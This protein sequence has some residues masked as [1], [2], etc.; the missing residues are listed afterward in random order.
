MGGR[1][2]QASIGLLLGA[3]CACA[4][5][6]QRPQ[7]TSAMASQEAEKQAELAV[8]ERVKMQAR[9]S[10]VMYRLAR[11]NSDLCGVDVAY[12]IGTTTATLDS[13]EKNFKPAYQTAFSLSDQP[14]VLSIAP[15]SPASAAGLAPGDII[16]RLNGS[17]VP[18]GERGI[19]AFT[20]ALDGTY[21][22][23]MRLHVQHGNGKEQDIDLK[24]DRVCKY[25]AVVT[26]D[27]NVNAMAD[28]K[29]IAVTSGLLRFIESDDEL[30]LVLGHELGHDAMG[31]IKSQR[32]NAAVGAFV[33]ALLSVATGVN[34]VDAG[35]QI[36][37]GA[38]SQSFEDE[39]DY[40][41]AYYAARA[42]YNIHGAADFWRRMAVA[43]PKGIHSQGGSHP[44]SASRF[45]AIEQ[46][47]K[48]IE[49]KEAAK[50]PLVPNQKSS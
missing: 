12:R 47:I 46:T 36:G 8:K 42:G 17:S 40:V 6:T 7:V 38:Y 9:V 28:G 4:P 43:H 37:A 45:V 11:A 48:E 1:F 25:P 15:E 50:A 26:Y 5:T 21:G 31:H 24:P 2:W 44:S 29:Q 20:T 16:R 35:A 14:S 33:G 30:A 13:V 18:S 19:Q 41:G 23:P 34:M 10:A 3:T 49:S 32:G 22:G 27:D 39:A